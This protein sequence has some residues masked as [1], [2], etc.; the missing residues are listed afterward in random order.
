MEIENFY[1]IISWNNN[2]QDFYDNSKINKKKNI[3]MD[4]FGCKWEK[5]NLYIFFLLL[6]NSKLNLIGCKNVIRHK[7]RFEYFYRFLCSV[8]HVNLS[9]FSISWSYLMVH[10]GNHNQIEI[11]S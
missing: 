1:R 6:I 8:R 2:N 4:V 10:I 7:F 5:I 11:I 9:R 3:R